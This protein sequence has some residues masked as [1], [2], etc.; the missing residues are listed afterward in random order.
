MRKNTE[1]E[2]KI[3]EDKIIKAIDAMRNGEFVLI[4]D[5]DARERE[6]DMV[7]GAEF[8]TKEKVAK[9]RTDAG[10]LICIAI[11]PEKSKI[12]KLPFLTEVFEYA[13]KKFD[14]LNELKANDIPYDEKSSFSLSINHRKTFTGITD[15]DR[16][17]TISEFANLAKN[18]GDFGKMFRTPGHVP[19]L[20]AADGLVLNRKGHTELSVALAEMAGITPVTC[21]C[22]MLDPK[23]GRALSKKDVLRYARKNN[24]VFVDGDDIEKAY[25]TWIKN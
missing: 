12:L 25:K 14:I 15:F 7:I 9:M 6:T 8:V 5:D 13:S 21:I 18:G 22:E 1:R 17:L 20:R 4:F 11:H 24:L 23:S 10:G 2:G 16:A 3:R 19:L